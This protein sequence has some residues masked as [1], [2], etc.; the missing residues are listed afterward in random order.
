MTNVRFTAFS[1]QS[2]MIVNH[3]LRENFDEE[4]DVFWR[5]VCFFDI[6]FYAVQ[7]VYH[8]KSHKR[9][10]RAL[11]NNCLYVQFWP[12]LFTSLSKAQRCK[13]GEC[14]AARSSKGRQGTVSFSPF[15]FL[16]LSIGMFV[17][18]FLRRHSN[19]FQ[20]VIDRH[21]TEQGCWAVYTVVDDEIVELTASSLCEAKGIADSLAAVSHVVQC[22]DACN[23]WITY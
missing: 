23:E 12:A 17:M 2:T 14:S 4:F 5:W 16:P 8:E 10:H 11:K 9:E 7:F 6:Q 22:N 19:G 18:P 20:V 1:S 21:P 3:E 15:G 13:A